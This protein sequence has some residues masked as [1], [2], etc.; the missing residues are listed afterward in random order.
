AGH[1]DLLAALDLVAAVDLEFAGVAIDGDQPV[2]VAHENRVAEFLEPVAGIDD[3]AVLGS[4][5]RRTLRHRDADAVVRLAAAL[6][7]LRDDAAADRPAHAADA[8]RVGRR[9]VGLLDDLLGLLRRR[10]D[11]DLLA[12]GGRFGRRR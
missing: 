2:L 4:L 9:L 10:V 1:R 12:L 7:V 8:G 3:D 11:G 6:A 5:H